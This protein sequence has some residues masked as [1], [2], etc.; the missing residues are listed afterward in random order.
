MEHVDPSYL[1]TI[2]LLQWGNVLLG[3]RSKRKRG[4]HARRVVASED[5]GSFDRRVARVYR[6]WT[7]L[8]Y[9]SGWWCG[10]HVVGPTVAWILPR[11][12]PTIRRGYRFVS[13]CTTSA[14]VVSVPGLLAVVVSVKRYTAPAVRF[15]CDNVNTAI[16]VYDHILSTSCSSYVHY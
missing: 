5:L 11:V 2:S 6:R 9:A 12:V 16:L 10:F 7:Q 15:I 8:K 14:A 13:Y 3:F 1:Y 4:R